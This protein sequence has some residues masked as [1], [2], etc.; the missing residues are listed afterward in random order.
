MFCCCCFREKKQLTE[1]EDIYEEKSD[2]LTSLIDIAE[3]KKIIWNANPLSYKE[4]NELIGT[5]KHLENKINFKKQ[6]NKNELKT[7]P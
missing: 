6:P 3:K 4:Y 1:I 7:S 5:A 2:T